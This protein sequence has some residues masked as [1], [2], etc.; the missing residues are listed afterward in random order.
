MFLEKNSQQ[1]VQVSPTGDIKEP[2]KV[3]CVYLFDFALGG[4]ST[5]H[6]ILW[7]WQAPLSLPLHL[8][9]Q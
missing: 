9:W 1:S 8:Y 7:G 4:T 2:Q 5:V 3:V 6:I